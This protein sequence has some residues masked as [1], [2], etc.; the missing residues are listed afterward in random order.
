MAV[1]PTTRTTLSIGKRT[2]TSSQILAVRTK[3][4]PHDAMPG[5][6]VLTVELLLDIRSDVLFDVVLLEG[7]NTN[8]NLLILMQQCRFLKHAL[9]GGSAKGQQKEAAS[10]EAPT[11]IVSQRTF[12]AQSIASV[13][14]S[15]DMS[16]FLITALRSDMVV[17]VRGPFQHKHNSDDCLVRDGNESRQCS[18]V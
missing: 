7:L 16:A 15:S 17:T 12:A 14:M 4:A 13:C 6:V 3:V 5:G 2:K 9:S 11:F 18:S 1:I 10:V 8:S